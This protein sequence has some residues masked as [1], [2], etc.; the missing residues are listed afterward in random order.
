MRVSSEI[1]AV[2]ISDDWKKKTEADI[3]A[4]AAHAHAP[5]AQQGSV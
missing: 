3:E 5:P 2:T 1:D 4:G